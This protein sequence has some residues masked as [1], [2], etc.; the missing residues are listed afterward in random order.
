VRML[1]SPQLA[2]KSLVLDVSRCDGVVSAD[3]EK[4]RQILIN[5][6]ANAIKFT[7]DGGRITVECDDDGGEGNGMVA[8][9]VRDTGI[10]IPVERLESVFEPFVQ[11]H[12]TLSQPAEGT[13]LGL[14]ISR[15]LARGM[16]GDLR[17]ERS[18][19]GASFVL[20]LPSDRGG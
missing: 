10:G 18:A 4:V 8:V 12:R 15:E 5:R 13:G 17:A 3:S 16:G 6:V 14:A 2:S 11:L 1:V 9:R 19:G 20:T 7:P